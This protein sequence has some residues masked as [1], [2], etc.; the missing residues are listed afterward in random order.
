MV[1]VAAAVHPKVKL[2]W[3]KDEKV[4]FV[5]TVLKAKLRVMEKNN[6]NSASASETMVSLTD[7]ES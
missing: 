1:K 6:S 3:V 5:N 4:D 7:G 2:Y